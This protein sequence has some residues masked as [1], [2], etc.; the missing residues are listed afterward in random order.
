MFWTD[1]LIKIIQKNN[2][3]CRAMIV[4]SDGSTPREEGASMII[5]KNEIKG[6]IGGGNLEFEV[7]NS[8]RKKIKTTSTFLREKK[9]FPL[10][11]NLGQCCGGYVEVLLEYYNKECIPLLKSLAKSNKKFILHPLEK[12]KFPLGT[13][14]KSHKSFFFSNHFKRYQPVFI[15]GA[16]HVGRA[17]INVTNDLQIDRYWVDI[18]KDRFPKNL[19]K[20]LN[21]LIANDLKI[22]AHNALP[23]S[24]HIVMTFSHH[25]DEEI[26]EIILQ[27]N[28]FF[29]LGLIGSKTKKIRIFN[30]LKKRGLSD[31]LLDKVTCPV[32]IPEVF[33]K[34]P[35]QVALSIASQLSNWIEG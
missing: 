16:G 19:P 7:I 15:Y 26:V 21:K 34:K 8:A 23:N 20:N 6:T 12:H 25:M 22:I 35:P 24:I 32:G 18:S 13:N 27:K 2:F 11:P 9:N 31:I 17:L 33:G 4:R 1:E 30:R 10:G 3:V 14:E 5:L 28:N 29:K